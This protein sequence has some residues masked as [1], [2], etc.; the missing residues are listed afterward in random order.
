MVRS[1]A[2]RSEAWEGLA[3]SAIVA[4]VVAAVSAA[5]ACS[6]ALAG[7]S[8]IV[9]IRYQPAQSAFQAADPAGQVSRLA[10]LADGAIAA[11]D[12][13]WVVMVRTPDGL[14][15]WSGE[16]PTDAER[17]IKRQTESLPAG[18]AMWFV[19]VQG[20]AAAGVEDPDAF[21][22]HVALRAGDPALVESYSDGNTHSRAYDA[23]GFEALEGAAIS[24]QAAAH[25]NTENGRWRLTL[26]T[27]VVMTEY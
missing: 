7:W 4:A 19:H 27:P 18:E 21:W 9:D 14:L 5:V 25:L 23:P 6:F 22:E 8:A 1:R 10:A 24:L 2:F 12:R 13:L 16:E 17:W 15:R 20:N 11:E 3:K 26:G